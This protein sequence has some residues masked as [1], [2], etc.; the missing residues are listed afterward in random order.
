M[1]SDQKAGISIRIL[2]SPCIERR[3]GITKGREMKTVVPDK[4]KSHLSGVWVM[5]DKGDKVRLLPNEWELASK[6]G[7]Q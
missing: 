7:S 6:G 4:G 5:G 1:K 3:H 2:V